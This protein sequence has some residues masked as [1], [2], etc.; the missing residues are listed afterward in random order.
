MDIGQ[1]GGYPARFWTVV[2]HIFLTALVLATD[3]LFNPNALDSEARKAKVLAAY[4]TLEKSKGE[5]GSP[6][7]RV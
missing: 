7:Q 2:Q 3:V 5:S 6:V 4:K 1:A